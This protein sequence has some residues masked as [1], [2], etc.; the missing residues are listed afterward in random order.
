MEQMAT[1]EKCLGSAWCPPNQIGQEHVQTHD[2]VCQE[3]VSEDVWR[4]CPHLLE[5]E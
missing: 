2:S 4:L 3:H 5:M 1:V